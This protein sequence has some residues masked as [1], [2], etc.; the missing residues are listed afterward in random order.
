LEQALLQRDERGGGEF[1]ISPDSSEFPC[2]AV[3][4]SG[5]IGDVHFFPDADS[6]GFRC[7]AGA[8]PPQ[9]GT[10]KLLYMGCDP[11]DGE[12][13]PSEFIVPF[14]TIVQIALAFLAEED[15][16]TLG[17]WFEL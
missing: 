13:S 14:A 9:G 3:R 12:D 16:L 10:T 2:L 6:P 4:I 1:W 5:A 11:A 7:L 17:H 15:P 8:D